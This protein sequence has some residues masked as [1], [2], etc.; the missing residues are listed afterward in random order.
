M[1]GAFF[2]KVC[3]LQMAIGWLLKAIFLS[4]LENLAETINKASCLSVQRAVANR[5]A[6]LTSGRD[7]SVHVC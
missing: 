7:R 5:Q 4:I 6:N 3:H 2:N 1:N